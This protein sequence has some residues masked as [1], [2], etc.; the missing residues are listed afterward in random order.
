MSRSAQVVIIVL[1]MAGSVP[2]LKGSQSERASAHANRGVAL[3]EQYRFADAADAAD[4]AEAFEAFV[5]LVPEDASGHINLGIADFN[6]RDF[7]RARASLERAFELAPR[8]TRTFTTTSV[9][10]TSCKATLSLRSKRSSASLG[11]TRSI[12]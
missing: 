2:G 4:A 7:D 3:L 11:S 1:F 5:Q 8:T 12:R 6:E 10:S 9:S